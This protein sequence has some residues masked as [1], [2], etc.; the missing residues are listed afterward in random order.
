[1]K[2]MDREGKLRLQ[3]KHKKNNRLKDL[4][5]LL[6]LPPKYFQKLNPFFQEILLLLLDKKHLETSFR[7]RKLAESRQVLKQS[8]L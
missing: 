5:R 7:P 6:A 2:K 3:K 8:E 4:G 1:M